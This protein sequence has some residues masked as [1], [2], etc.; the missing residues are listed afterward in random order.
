MG[1]TIT[2][3]ASSQALTTIARI[4]TELGISG[5]GDDSLLTDLVLDASDYIVRYCGRTFVKETVTETLPSSGGVFLVLSRRPISSISEI[6]FSGDV[7]DSSDYEIHEADSGIVYRSN[8]WS[9]TQATYQSITLREMPSTGQN[10]Y[11]VDY[12]AGYT[13]RAMDAVYYD[14]PL[15]VERACIELAKQWYLSRCRDKNVTADGLSGVYS[16]SYKDQAM[17]SSVRRLLA[18]WVSVDG[19][20]R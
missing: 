4:K 10:L 13:T 8:G 6:R 14:L 5:S 12:V 7:V 11:A 17:P 9:S 19:A 15:S 1:V 3:A 2:S 20:A 18:P 16:S